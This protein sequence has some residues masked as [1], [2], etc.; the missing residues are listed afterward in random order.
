MAWQQAP[1]P[2]DSPGSVK[3]ID[4]DPKVSAPDPKK[5]DLKD[6]EETEEDIPKPDYVKSK[7]KKK[8][9]KKKPV[10]KPKRKTRTEITPPIVV[11][12][13]SADRITKNDIRKVLLENLRE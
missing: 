5:S 6:D 12:G 9:L 3:T 4:K 8:K 2:S 1:D 7:S 13:E 11:Q 10:E